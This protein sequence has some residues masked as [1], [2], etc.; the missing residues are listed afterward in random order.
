[1]TDV[2][3]FDRGSIKAI[4]SGASKASDVLG[5]AALLAPFAFDAMDAQGHGGLRAG[6]FFEDAVVLSEALLVN[7]AL[8]EIVKGIASRPRP[9]AYTAAP[10][11]P[12][13]QSTETY[14]SFYS[15]HTSATF[16]AGVA[17]ARTYQFRHPGSSATKWIYAGAIATGATVGA[18]RVAAGKHF[19]S[20][21]IAGAVAG[22]L[23]GWF[24][25][26]WHHREGAMGATLTPL[27]GGGQL[28]LS[29]GFR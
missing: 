6:G 25:P 21:A 11:D 4:R 10:S 19:P 8:N 28:G 7:Q 18:L 26:T 9:Y 1:M 20:D 3:R 13:L 22:S 2:N 24:I 14:T 15:A 27:P 12:V 29:F 5:S 17:Y 16:A 23:A